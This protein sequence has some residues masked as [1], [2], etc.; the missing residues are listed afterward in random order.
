MPFQLG[1][2][3]DFSLFQA[4]R[5]SR[6][7]LVLSSYLCATQLNFDLIEAFFVGLGLKERSEHFPSECLAIFEVQNLNFN[8]K[9]L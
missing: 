8:K 1:Q 6:I 9:K 7:F 5:L 3:L 2:F 4:C